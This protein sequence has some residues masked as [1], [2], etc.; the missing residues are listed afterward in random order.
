MSV[1]A[2]A[3]RFVS[4]VLVVI[5][6]LSLLRTARA[7]G[8]SNPALTRAE[9]ASAKQDYAAAE[10][11]YAEALDKG[12]LSTAETLQCHV[13]LGIARVALGKVKEARAAFRSA[14]LLDPHFFLP[15]D[16][17]R[18]VRAI[19]DEMRRDARSTGAYQITIESP[20]SAPA[21]RSFHVTVGMSAAHAA[22]AA[23]VRLLAT[24]PGSDARFEKLEPASTTVGFDVPAS[25]AV[26]DQI[27]A[28]TVEAVDAH[29][30]RLVVAS[31]RVTI[32]AGAG[33]T[34]GADAGAPAGDGGA[35]GP[36]APTV[37]TTKT[38]GEEGAAEDNAGT[39]PWSVP[40]G[41]KK[42][43]ATRADKPPVIDGTLDDPIWA[44]A[45]KDNR[46]FSTRS[47]PYGQAT[48]EPTVVQIA[49]DE[50]N[51]YVAF[52]CA[53]AKPGEKDDTFAADEVTLLTESESVS[54]I[55]D[56][57]HGH[58][59]AYQFAVSPV[60]ARAD[61][62]LSEQGASANTDWTGIWESGTRRTAAGWTAELRIPW[63]TMR[64]PSHD[65]PFDLGL[66]F[67]RR[68]P[69]SGEYSLWSLH[70]PATE[71]FD[72]NYFGHLDGLSN[73][74]PGQRLYLEP[75]IAFAYDST[76]NRN[77]SA[78]SDFTGTHGNF[79][80]YAGAYARLRPPGPF[81]MDATFNPDFSAVRPDQALAN[82]D[83]FEIEFPEARPFF[84]ED[85]P[86]FQF[87]APRYLFGDLGAQLFY[88]RRL[89]IDTNTAGLTQ[90]VPILW[91]VKSVM[92]AGGTEAA[93]MNVETSPAARTISLS[94]NATVGRVTETIM[95][96]RLGAIFLN[97]A[98]DSG[99][100][101]SGG[102]DVA[103]S[104]YDRHLQVSGFYAG[105]SFSGL[106][107]SGAGAGTLGWKSQDVY[108][109]ATY[110]DIGKS[111]EAPLGFFPITGVQSEQF[112]AGYTPVLRS[113]LVQQVLIDGQ[114]TL[115]KDRDTGARIFDRGVV[116]GSIQTIQQAL[117]QVGVAPAIENVTAPFPIGN[118]RI[119]VAPGTYKVLVTQIDFLSP[120]RAR[121]V[122]GLGYTGGDLFDGLRRA[123]SATFGLNLGRFSTRAKYTLFLLR[124]GPEE[125][126][127]HEI[128]ANASYAYSPRAKTT[129]IVDA[130]TVAARATA[131]LVTAIQFWTAST[132]SLAVRATS[133]STIDIAA[134]DW[135]DNPNVSAILS[136]ALGVTPF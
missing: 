30:N 112:A 29:D 105:S 114:L 53:Y 68:E 103:L 71:E 120:P 46:F 91:G 104:F 135:S 107:V 127:G 47:K 14:A 84:A 108:A 89:G 49:Y 118:G 41:T 75:Y 74:H 52:R 42:Y 134:L 99:G 92:R 56:P 26:S 17:G 6:T 124:Y 76:P 106:G 34:A 133:G 64:M 20:E 37:I 87:G 132:I 58:T 128:D 32:E 67:A 66:N 86:R 90:A 33:S 123:P 61:V 9:A 12:G 73:V 40:H 109:Q 54:V 81:R 1:A 25:V 16:T 136:F 11:L 125:F 93:I 98:G 111:F 19:A 48:L 43:T 63:G 95:G 10:A 45:P 110:M 70:P 126:A 59:G 38:D 69:S 130:N 77:I 80:V 82:F 22:L 119:T 121:V 8:P 60:G 97:R 100:Y 65:E 27:V 117:V 13:Q 21:G 50:E 57:V 4:V 102:G 62:E 116:A 122:W 39:G 78:L 101:T 55:V 15:Q 23:K 2:A 36:T 113:D 3:R 85:N 72:T 18:K 28:L 35:P 83:R 88:S 44:K 96:Q 7:D 115:A 5:A 129:L 51:L 79:R 31:A 131:Q 24:V 94:D